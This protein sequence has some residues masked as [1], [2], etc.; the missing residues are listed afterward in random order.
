ML[1]LNYHVNF[2]LYIDAL[3]YSFIFLTTTIAFFVYIYA[4]AYFRYEPHVDR[5]LIFL[6]LFVMSMIVLTAAGNLAVLF[7][8]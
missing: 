5:L 3:A 1:N 4:F 2:I 7:L 8:G 6:N